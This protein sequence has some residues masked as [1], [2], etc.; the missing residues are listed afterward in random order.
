MPGWIGK[1]YEVVTVVVPHLPYLG[2][3]ALLALRA[4]CKRERTHILVVADRSIPPTLGVQ[5]AGARSFSWYPDRV[6]D[7]LS[8]EAAAFH[9]AR[10][11]SWVVAPFHLEVPSKVIVLGTAEQPAFPF[12]WIP[13]PPAEGGQAVIREDSDWQE[14]LGYL[15]C[16]EIELQLPYLPEGYYFCKANRTLIH[17][18]SR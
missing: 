14:C 16:Q 15:R 6:R 9:L 5:V 1:H 12:P 7:P 11:S 8:A 17:K 10:S 13:L 3:H 2:L 18:A 4:L